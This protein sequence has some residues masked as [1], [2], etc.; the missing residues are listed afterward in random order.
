MAFGERAGASELPPHPPPLP[1]VEPGGRGQ[2]R[3]PAGTPLG[4]CRAVGTP[5]SSLGEALLSP[6]GSSRG[7]Q[8]GVQTFLG[9]QRLHSHHPE[10]MILCPRHAVTL[11]G[12]GG[13]TAPRSPTR[14]HVETHSSSCVSSEAQHT[15]AHTHTHTCACPVVSAE[16]RL[17]RAGGV[18]REKLSTGAVASALTPV[19][20]RGHGALLGSCLLP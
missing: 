3:R 18:C 15:C 5:P 19:A 2:E 13:G 4:S 9:G 11:S 12:Q 10:N 6:K 16:L 1:H 20:T 17:C 8:G 14:Q 7:G